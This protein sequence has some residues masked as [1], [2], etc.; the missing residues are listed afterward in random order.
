MQQVYGLAPA[1][2]DSAFDAWFRA[3]FSRELMA[4]RGVASGDEEGGYRVSGPFREAMVAATTAVRRKAWPEVIRAAQSAVS[5]LPEFAEGGSGYHL[6]VDAQLAR[7]DTA[8]AVAALT[9][10]TS[11]NGDAVDENLTLARLL[12]ARRDT[13]GAVAALERAT[14][15]DPFD[16]AVQARLAGLATSTRQWATAVRARRAVLALGPSDRAEAFYRLAQA[17][18]G[19]GDLAGARR[20]VLRALDLAPTFEA[21]QDLLLT[22]RST[23]RAP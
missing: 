18:V 16:G 15:I 7:G 11:R 21:A 9:A 20:E 8:A 4:V 17:L 1:A 22:I 14:L 5:M 12:E 13:A 23:P 2:L 3:K 19:A 10:I 6:L